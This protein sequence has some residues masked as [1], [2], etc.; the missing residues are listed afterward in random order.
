MTS[1]GT[2]GPFVNAMSY[3]MRFARVLLLSS[4]DVRTSFPERGEL[5]RCLEA[6]NHSSAQCRYVQFSIW[7]LTP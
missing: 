4:A 7:N 2:S 1:T 6:G 3:F 5:A